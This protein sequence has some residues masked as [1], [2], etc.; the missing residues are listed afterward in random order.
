[1]FFFFSFIEE[2]KKQKE[3]LLDSPEISISADRDQRTLPA[4]SADAV[5]WIPAA[6]EKAGE[7]FLR[8]SR[9]WFHIND[10][11]KRCNRRR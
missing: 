1:M 9:F 7:T 10:G 8:A 3:E 2:K 5:P 6:F 4:A 11:L